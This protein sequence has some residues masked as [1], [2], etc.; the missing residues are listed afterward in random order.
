MDSENNMEELHAELIM[1]NKK[2]KD[3]EKSWTP[4][5]EIILKIWAE[6]AAGYRWLHNKAARHYKSV[7]DR[8]SLSSIFLT[9]MAGLGSFGAGNSGPGFIYY[10]ICAVNVLSAFL[11]SLQKFYKCAEKA[12]AHRSVSRQ[13]ATLYRNVSVEL[14][15]APKHRSAAKDIAR[16]C[17]NDYERLMHVAP[18]VPQKVVDVFKTKFGDHPNK[19]EIA[20]GLSE[21]R[22]YDRDDQMKKLKDFF[23]DTEKEEIFHD[24]Q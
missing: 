21:I 4:E 17:R 19:P 13:F 5:Q 6:K 9:T 12:E 7:N 15:L 14:T 11:T 3:L 24:T 20:N 1:K 16:S 10:V 18:C 8:L 22:I 2:V 23:T